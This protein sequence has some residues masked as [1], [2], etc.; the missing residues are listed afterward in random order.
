MTPSPLTRLTPLLRLTSRSYRSPPATPYPVLGCLTTAGG[1]PDFQD[2]TSGTRD[3]I[4]SERSSHG[5]SS[6]TSG[7]RISAQLL[8]VAA[9]I[10]LASGASMSI[11]GA[12]P[13]VAILAVDTDR[14]MGAIDKNIYG[15]FLEH[16]NHSVV[17]GL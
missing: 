5:G 2:P 15:Q 7:L 17:D 10:A 8:S 4:Y 6:M 16:I 11:R 3:W 12:E 1:F 13:G 14:P 9:G